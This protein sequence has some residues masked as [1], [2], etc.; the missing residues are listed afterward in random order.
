MEW[1]FLRNS[2]VSGNITPSINTI[3]IMKDLDNFNALI[4]CLNIGFFC[5]ML[6]ILKYATI[7]DNL[8]SQNQHSEVKHLINF[9][10][11]T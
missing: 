9:L 11:L 4:S 2:N 8:I 1:I 7:I 5:T 6:H 10:E 3:E